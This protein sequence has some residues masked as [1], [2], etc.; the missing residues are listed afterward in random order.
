LLRAE[1]RRLKEST[2][3]QVEGYVTIAHKAPQEFADDD[4][5]DEE[6]S[7]PSHLFQPRTLNAPKELSVKDERCVIIYPDFITEEEERYLVRE[8]NHPK[9]AKWQSVRNRRLQCFGGDP[10]PQAPRTSLPKWLQ[11][12]AGLVKLS[13]DVDYEVDHVLLNEYRE[14]QGILPHTDGPSYHPCV[15]CL[16]IGDACGTMRFQSKLK[17]ED[18]GAK[19]SEDL[20]MVTLEPRSLIV[21]FGAAYSDALHSIEDVRDGDVRISLTLRKILI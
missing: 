4:A 10:V 18:I 9:R 6:T 1:K 21:F 14:G 3:K 19:Q 20:L 2:T 8:A 7:V 12:L 11:S 5:I 17:S 15:A 13:P 16:S